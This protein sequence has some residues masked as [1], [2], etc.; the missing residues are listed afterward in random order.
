MQEKIVLFPLRP[1]TLREYRDEIKTSLDKLQK[2][3]K[4]R[5]DG[6]LSEKDAYYTIELSDGKL[7]RFSYESLYSHRIVYA[8]RMISEDAARMNQRGW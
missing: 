7:I 4:L 1:K 2:L 6:K 5:A 3:R 8:G